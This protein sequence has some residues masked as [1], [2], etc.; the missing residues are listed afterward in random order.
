MSL[1]KDNTVPPVKQGRTIAGI[2]PAGAVQ[3]ISVDSDGRIILGSSVTS[4]GTIEPHS[5]L[6]DGTKAVA[7]AGTAEALAATTTVKSVL[8]QALYA[9]T[10]AILIG[11][12]TSQSVRLFPGDVAVYLIDDLAKVFVDAA[13]SA[14]G[15]A[16]QALQ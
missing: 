11:N 10:G 12:A 4:G 13:V 2:D 9:N 1:P 16:F 8:V 5:T 15:V 7:S 6:L 14:E 3:V